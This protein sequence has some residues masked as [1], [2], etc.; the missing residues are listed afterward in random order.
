MAKMQ[1]I[2]ADKQKDCEH[3]ESLD[4]TEHAATFWKSLT[5][6]CTASHSS[7]DLQVHGNKTQ[8]QS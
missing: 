3:S 5:G 1:M 8:E 6:I 4:V 2:N 7:A